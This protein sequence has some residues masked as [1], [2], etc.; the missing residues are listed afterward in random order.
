MQ[1]LCITPIGFKQDT[2]SYTYIFN[3]DEFNDNS[4]LLDEFCND[5]TIG[6]EYGI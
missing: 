4:D 3:D 1:I 2:L 6:G 5:L